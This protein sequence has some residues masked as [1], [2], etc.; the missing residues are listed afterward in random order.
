MEFAAQKSSPAGRKCIKTEFAAPKRLFRWKEVR[1]NGV[2]SIKRSLTLEGSA[3]KQSLQHQKVSHAGRKCV[4]AKF[5]APKRLSRLKEVRQNGVCSTKK[6]L[7]L[8]VSASKPSLQHQ[9]VSHAESKCVK[10]EFAAS[11][12]L[13]R[14]K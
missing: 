4:K 9:K 14:W 6:A 7:P 2:C 11:K 1:Q 12:G 5:A 3:S 8:E 10:T 13:S